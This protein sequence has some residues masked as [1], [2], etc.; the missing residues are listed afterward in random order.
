[1]PIAV[2]GTTSRYK[3]HVVNVSFRNWCYNFVMHSMIEIILSYVLY[4]QIDFSK[5]LVSLW[6][7]WGM[8]LQNGHLKDVVSWKELQK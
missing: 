7:D 6:F 8:G 3:N 1:M 4:L 5:F 2:C